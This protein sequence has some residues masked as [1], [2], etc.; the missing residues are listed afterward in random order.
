MAAR[1]SLVRAGVIG[2][3]VLVAALIGWTGGHRALGQALNGDSALAPAAEWILQGRVYEGDVGLEP[4]NAV[5]K[6]GIAVQVYGA[7]AQYPAAGHFIR[8]TTTDNQGYYGLSVYDDDGDWAYYYIL[9]VNPWGYES[10]GAT[11]VGGTVRTADWIEY[12]APLTGKT[13]TGNKFWDKRPVTA[14][15]SPTPTRTPSPTPTGTP[16]A[17]ASPTRTPSATAT[18]SPSPTPTATPH[19][20]LTP[21]RTPTAT[22]PPGLTPSPTRTGTPSAT[23]TATLSRTQTPTASP[24]PTA[25]LPVVCP[26]VL[27]NGDFE[28]S[29]LAPWGVSAQPGR[30]GAAARGAPGWAAWTM[31]LASYG[32]R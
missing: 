18:A 4:P 15:P 14:S 30:T 12:A 2:A 5:P 17:T 26:D 10:A 20:T 21:T 22:L 3:A 27:V 6:Q 19:A 11:T 28:A 23:P 31:P 7:A 25:T 24:T 29:T 16:I 9:E 32:S 1:N 13:L 8:G